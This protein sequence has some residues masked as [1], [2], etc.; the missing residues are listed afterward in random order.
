MP[1]VKPPENVQYAIRWWL[2][3]FDRGSIVGIA[4][5]CV[6][7]MLL[8][9]IKKQ[10]KNPSTDPRELEFIE[11]DRRFVPASDGISH[12]DMAASS[13]LRHISGKEHGLGWD[14]LLSKRLVVVLGEPYSGKTR[15]FEHRVSLLRRNGHFSLFVHL[16]RLVKEEFDQAIGIDDKAYL[17]KWINSTRDGYFFL[18]SV[19]EAKFSR[20]KDFHV[21]LDRI[22]NALG[23]PALRRARLFISSR[24]WDWQP[25]TDKSEVLWRFSPPDHS[26]APPQAIPLAKSASF[27]ADDILVVQLEPLDESRIKK[28]VE[29]KDPQNASLFLEALEESSAWEFARRP[30]DVIDM[31]NYWRKQNR[32]GPLSEIIDFDVQSKLQLPRRDAGDTLSPQKAREGVETLAASAILCRQ[33][34]FRIYDP[35]STVDS[36]D[37][38]NCLSEAWSERE[39]NSLL[40]RPIFDVASYGS[41]RF[42]HRRIVEYLG[43]QWFER[44]MRKGC[45]IPEIEGVLF[46]RSGEERVIRAGLAPVAAWLCCGEERWNAEVRSWVLAAAPD[47]HL[48][49]GDPQRLSVQYRLELLKAIVKRSEGRKHIWIES[50]GDSL[51]RFADPGLSDYVN[52]VVRNERI[53]I[54]MRQEMLALARFGQLQGCLVVALEI[55]ASINEPDSLKS[56]AGA[57][58]RDIG[59]PGTRLML[60]D[61]SRRL[62]SISNGLCSRFCEALFPSTI[63]N[64]QLIDLLRKTEFVP[65]YS[66]DLPDYL[67]WHLKGVLGKEDIAELLQCLLALGQEPPHITHDEKSEGISAQFHWVAK[68]FPFL[69]T[70]L[71]VKDPLTYEE[72]QLSA[73][74]IRFLTL[75]NHY[76][77][78]HFHDIAELVHALGLHPLIRRAYHWQLVDESDPVEQN[79]GVSLIQLYDHYELFNLNEEDIDWMIQDIHIRQ[80]PRDRSLALRF[81]LEL[82]SDSKNRRDYLRRIRKAIANDHQLRMKFS[83]WHVSAFKIW[84]RRNLLWKVQSLNSEWFWIHQRNRLRSIWKTLREQIVLHFHIRLLFSG[85]AVVWLA[86]LSREAVEDSSHYSPTSWSRLRRKRGGLIAWAVKS[87]CKRSWRHF[88]SLLP[89]EKSNPHSTGYPTIVGLAGVQAAFMDDDISLDKLTA[90]EVEVMTRHAT[91]ELNG[92][93]P[94]F[95]EVAACHPCPVRTVLNEAIRGEWLFKPE[96]ESAQEVMYDL[97]WHAE[98]LLPLFKPQVL[99]LL[100]KSD[101]PNI[102][103]LS[104]ALTFLLKG[105]DPSLTEVSEI[106]SKRTAQYPAESPQ[107]NLW[108]TVWLQVDAGRALDFLEQIV[109]RCE[110]PNR[111]ALDLCLSLKSDRIERVPSVKDPSYLF[112]VHLKRLITFVFKYVRPDEDIQHTTGVYTPEARDDAQR[113]RGTL[114]DRLANGEE[115]E[116]DIELRA[117]LEDPHLQ[118][119]RD[120]LLHLIDVR[121]RRRADMLPWSPKDIRDFEADFEIDPKTDS[122]LSKMVLRRLNDIRHDVEVSDQS[123]RRDLHPDDDERRLRQWL[124]TQL[125][126]R[127]NNKYIVP[128]EIEIDRQERPDIRVEH[129]SVRGAIS[130]EVKLMDRWSLNQ[131]QERL[132]NQLLGQYM[133]D[134]NSRFG[135]YFLG[136]VK[137]R[138][139][140]EDHASGRNINYEEVIQILTKQAFDL[141]SKRND[142]AGIAVVGVDFIDP[143]S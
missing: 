42:H 130:I 129:P 112:P 136:Y 87:G 49:Y 110:N 30:G 65:D 21:S 1:K 16:D 24:I 121:K 103:I 14:E 60:A 132:E 91:N 84:W 95:K 77:N 3:F 48:Q 113:F 82:R 44:M 88:R 125:S 83:M 38:H 7:P 50:H 39:V 45:S 118:S 92:F 135:V 106:A 79:G 71:F 12:E 56:H 8:L 101:P 22:R 31:L 27:P 52:S 33:F 126:K 107:F 20:L 9:P 111:I 67:E 73:V 11:L 59:D 128:Q 104:A 75:A 90:E 57:L 85:K 37:A 53:S 68:L 19:D 99:E 51:K 98:E 17:Q 10:S 93:P 25:Q 2:C 34:S 63:N 15:E 133:R 120:F 89:H 86:E 115:E 94:W 26:K 97:L 5:Q 23:P 58:V 124:A 61:I 4:S 102:A 66:V 80:T 109:T 35:N 116:A 139:H 36:L 123:I 43:A 141:C 69:L 119:S 81:A 105:K 96:R 140:W 137:E 108:L 55:I 138:S 70:K 54:D 143:H 18:D 64:K 72:I 114:L 78:G 62:P 100:R 29:A 74:A 46:D 28:F 47:I 76:T 142:V 122:D 6:E 134:R 117:L 40:D 13:Y 131:L 32:F 127:S 41:I